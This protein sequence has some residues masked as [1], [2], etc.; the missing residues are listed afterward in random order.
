[1]ALGVLELGAGRSQAAIGQ[2]LACQAM[3]Q[4]VAVNDPD[5]APAPELV[6]A[7]LRTGRVAE[8]HA[9]A[10]GYDA[11]A[12]AKGQPF[13]LARAARVRGLLAADDAYGPHFE[14]ALAHHAGTLD[15]FDQARTRL[16]YGE[17]LR[18][19]RRRVQAR[20]QLRA[21]LAAFDRL[22]ARPWAERALAELV[23]SGESARVRD[24][25][26]RH[27]LTPQELQ[28]ALALA[29][30]RTTREAAAKLYL[31]PKTVEYH[32]RNVYD[33]LEIRSRE[34]LQAVLGPRAT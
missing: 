11:L 24:D 23:A 15:I 12:T 6:D 30:G 33:K 20:D 29:E 14:A 19:S 16:H 26:Y 5:L 18:R 7:Y 31:S 13:A 32:L 1:M 17:R 3:L 2:L 8:A 10:A 9:A 21:A 28:V 25:S 22:G 34:E 4:E 27:Q